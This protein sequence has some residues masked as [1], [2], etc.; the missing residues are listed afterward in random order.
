MG[1]AGS[2]TTRV[3]GAGLWNGFTLGPLSTVSALLV[4]M[5]VEVP[6]TGAPVV[7]AVV[8]PTTIFLILAVVSFARRQ[9]RTSWWVFSALGAVIGTT[10]VAA[11]I[12]GAISGIAWMLSD[13]G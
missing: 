7:A 8:G 1:V 10:L 9:G 6:R 13:P 5:L 11:A 2:G 12:L 4:I 3:H